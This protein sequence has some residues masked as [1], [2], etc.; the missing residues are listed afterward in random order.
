MK[1]MDR[2][3]LLDF[4][5]DIKCK[6]S[7]TN[8]CWKNM[9]AFNVIVLLSLNLINVSRLYVFAENPSIHRCKCLKMSVS[10]SKFYT[11]SNLCL[12]SV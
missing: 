12:L 3:N 10:D 8:K 9:I 5:S 1:L 4:D 7:T 11:L 6:S 2:Q